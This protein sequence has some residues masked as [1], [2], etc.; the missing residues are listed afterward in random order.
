MVIRECDQDLVSMSFVSKEMIE[1]A[2]IDASKKNQLPPRYMHTSL[3]KEFALETTDKPAKEMGKFVSYCL[4]HGI[5]ESDLE[6]LFVK[7]K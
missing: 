3:F 5:N 6:G 7:C 2:T 4:E 1:A